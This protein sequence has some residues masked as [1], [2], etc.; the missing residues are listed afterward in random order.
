MAAE[1]GEPKAALDYFRFALLMDLADFSGN[2]SDG[3]HVASAAGVWQALVFGFGGVRE[4]DGELSITPHLPAR[5]DLL[6]FS[7]QFRS[8]RV[9]IRLT[10][11]DETYTLEEGD[12][13]EI[14]I[15]GKRHVLAPGVPLTEPAMPSEPATTSARL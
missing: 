8:R 11:D 1:V 10:H 14:T 7:L 4:Y 15:R 6:A 2:A 3:V 12:S 9:R 13:L 5:W